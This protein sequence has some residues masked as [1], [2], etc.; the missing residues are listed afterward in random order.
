MSTPAKIQEDQE[1]PWE[2]LFLKAFLT[3][4]YGT[5]SRAAERAGVSPADVRR[6]EKE[7]PRFR[8]HLA[9]C[10][11]VLRDTV[12]YEILRRALEP[13]EKPVFHRGTIIGVIQEWDTKHL[14]WTAERLMPEEFHLPT[15]LEAGLGKDDEV[16]FRLE[17]NPGTKEEESEDE[18]G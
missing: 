12:R 7:S 17:L 14:E 10:R 6:R 16:N 13:T 1:E 9:T 18:F 3:E 5:V 8:S 4:T 15:R 2:R 11:E